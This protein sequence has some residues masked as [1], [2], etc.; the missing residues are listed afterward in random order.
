[1]GRLDRLAGQLFSLGA[2]SSWEGPSQSRP[3][4]LDVEA[5]IQSNYKRHSMSR[6]V[7]ETTS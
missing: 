6:N 5:F 2:S 4:S 3:R 7:S 1:V